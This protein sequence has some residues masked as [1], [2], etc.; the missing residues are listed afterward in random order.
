MR[1]LCFRK[2][3]ETR[4]FLTIRDRAAPGFRTVKFPDIGKIRFGPRNFEMNQPASVPASPVPEDM[5]IA[6]HAARIN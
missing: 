2:N 6:V 4:E 3:G 1:A 5:G